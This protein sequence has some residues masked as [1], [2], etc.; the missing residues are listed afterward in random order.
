MSFDI[1]KKKIKEKKGMDFTM[2]KSIKAV[3][4][5]ACAFAVTITTAIVPA[6]TV[7]A[8][9]PTTM[10]TLTDENNTSYAAIDPFSLGDGETYYTLSGGFTK[11]EWAPMAVDNIMSSTDYANVYSATFK[12]PA[13]KDTDEDRTKNEFKMC[14]IDNQVFG[15]GWERTLI[16]GTTFY[17][18]NMSRFRIPCEEETTV[19]IYWD[20]STGAV[21]VKDEAGNTLDYLVS[22]VGYDNELIWKT[23]EEVSKASWSEYAAD[24][25]AIAQGAGC[26]DIPDLA[27]LN[28]DLENKLGGAPS[29]TPETSAA[30]ETTTAAA[31]QATTAATQ[32]T[33]T[34]QTSTKTGDAAPIAM[35]VTLCAAAVVVVVAAKKKEA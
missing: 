5:L 33:T 17:G 24:K 28:A 12:L 8:E 3:S 32:S 19:T 27:K 15:N 7:K 21:V 14:T 6:M 2:R 18:D 35:V 22:L 11:V 9:I 16:A 20:T 25:A 29:N 23:P 30:A 4:A 34:A 31:A 13:F 1:R 10:E 26:K